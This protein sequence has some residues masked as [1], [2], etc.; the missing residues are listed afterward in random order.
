MAWEGGEG[1][2]KNKVKLIF[3]TLGHSYVIDSA[4]SQTSK[5]KIG[6]CWA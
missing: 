3:C 1:Q 6:P 4:A 2:E 5:D